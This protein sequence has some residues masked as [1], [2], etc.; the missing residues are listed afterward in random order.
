V[1]DPPLVIGDSV[2]LGSAEALQ[3]AL[4]AG[5]TVD[6]EVGRQFDHGP[7]IVAAWAATH[8]GPI[9]VHL[10]SNGIV[11][12][13]DIDAIVAA[14][15]QRRV[16]F[17]NVAVPRRWQQPDNDALRAGVARHA[18]R[19][20]LADWASVVAANPGLLGPDHVHPVPAGR[21]ALAAVISTALNRP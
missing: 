14:A 6:G 15:G 2:V 18:D 16:V 1:A 7:A 11:R 13:A 21:T 10:G 20:V 5:T 8:R 12:A 3:A 19:A 9:V 4:G 17:V